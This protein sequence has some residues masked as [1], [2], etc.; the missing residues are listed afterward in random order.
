VSYDPGKARN[1]FT[2]S[3]CT[4]TREFDVIP[5]TGAS[6]WPIIAQCTQVRV[7]TRHLEKFKINIFTRRI[8]TKFCTRKRLNSE[9]KEYFTHIAVQQMSKSSRD[10]QDLVDMKFIIFGQAVSKYTI[11]SVCVMF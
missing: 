7:Q 1:G 5:A 11:V 10:I 3:N 6:Y 4:Y 9:Y 8:Q 2:R